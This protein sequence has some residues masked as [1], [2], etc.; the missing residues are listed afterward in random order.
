M[1]LPA[2]GTPRTWSGFSEAMI[3]DHRLEVYVEGNLRPVQVYFASTITDQQ[4]LMLST[5]A[6]E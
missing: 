1:Q 4:K 2:W 5:S 3:G 6:I